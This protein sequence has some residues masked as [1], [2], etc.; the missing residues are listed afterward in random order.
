VSDAV[1]V[2][3]T[4]SLISIGT[5]LVAIVRKGGGSLGTTNPYAS[6]FNMIGRGVVKAVGRPDLIG[7]VNAIGGKVTP[8]L[9]VVGAFTGAY[10]TTIELQCRTGVIQ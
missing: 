2:A 9:A 5:D 6:G 8:M 10:N 7:K 4:A 1:A 3:E